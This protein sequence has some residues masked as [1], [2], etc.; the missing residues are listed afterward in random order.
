MLEVAEH[1]Y[2]FDGKSPI[3]DQNRAVVSAL[4]AELQ[5][6]GPH[7]PVYWGNRN[8]HPL[9]ADTLR[10]MESD[11]RKRTLAYVTSA[12]SSYS[13]CRQYREDI[14]KARAEVPGAPSVDKIRAFY[15]HPA[16]IEVVAE[17]VSAAIG[18]VGKD[19]K[20]L[21]TAHSIPMSMAQSS[22]Y[23][24]Q[25]NEASRLVAERLG[26]AEWRLVYQSRSG[27]PSQP[28]LAPD[29]NDAIRELHAAG[30]RDLVLSPIGFLSC[31]MEVLYDL[32]TESRELCDSLG[33]RMRRAL[34]PNADPKFI[35]M[36]GELIRERMGLAEARAIGQYPPN[37]DVC[38][39]GCCP[40]PV[41]RPAASA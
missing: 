40:A 37:H 1:Y 18:E 29:V 9:L 21:F 16:F 24:K 36:L 27:P 33:M 6:N 10:Q 39:V 30:V 5:Q 34:T 14:D 20:V 3:N 32:D 35:A 41:R 12:F 31:H 8:W 15:N 25:I 26:L 11:G 23:T 22:D 2:H 28:W 13:G 19:A 4:A 38:P 17:N 7:L